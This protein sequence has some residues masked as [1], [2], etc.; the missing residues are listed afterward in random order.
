MDAM[1]PEVSGVADLVTTLTTA[2]SHLSPTAPTFIPSPGT[3]EGAKAWL[4]ERETC[5]VRGE[6]LIGGLLDPV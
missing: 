4:K 3:G 1:K 2:G 5:S 6:K